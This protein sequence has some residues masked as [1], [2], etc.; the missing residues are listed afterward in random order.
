MC[1]GDADFGCILTQAFQIVSAEV[2]PGCPQGRGESCGLNLC[3]TLNELQEGVL[4][5]HL[6]RHALACPQGSHGSCATRAK[7]AHRAHSVH[8]LPGLTGLIGLL[9][10]LL[11]GFTRLM[12]SQGM[13]TG[14]PGLTGLLAGHTGLRGLLTG[15]TGIL[16][17]GR[18]N[19]N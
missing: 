13:H 17:R 1:S 15:L 16:T 11:T 3:S 19:L 18:G 7:R 14:F 4:Q 6:F 12:C 2:I 9:T 10:G 8:V 5:F